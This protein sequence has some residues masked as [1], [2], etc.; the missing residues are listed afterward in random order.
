MTWN[1]FCFFTNSC[2]KTYNSFF[3]TLTTMASNCS[4]NPDYVTMKLMIVHCAAIS[5][6]KCGLVSFVMRKSLNLRS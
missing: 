1:S 4:S 6:L 3:S 2:F 5:G